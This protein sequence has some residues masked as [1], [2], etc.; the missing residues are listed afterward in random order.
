MQNRLFSTSGSIKRFGLA[1][2]KR[3]VDI[4]WQYHMDGV[5]HNGL[6]TSPEADKEP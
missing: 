6:E 1:Y 2:V 3:G 4:W 5:E